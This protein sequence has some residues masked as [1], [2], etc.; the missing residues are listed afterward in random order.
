MHRRRTGRANPSYNPSENLVA[1]E[2]RKR[3]MRQPLRHIEDPVTS[4]VAL[5]VSAALGLLGVLVLGL[6]LAFGL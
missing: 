3:K 5:L 2:E 6:M 1:L 4:V